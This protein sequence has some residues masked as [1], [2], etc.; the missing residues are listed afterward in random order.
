M[1]GLPTCG[2]SNC[3]PFSF[4]KRVKRKEDLNKIRIGGEKTRDDFETNIGED[5]AAEKKVAL[6]NTLLGSAK[7]QRKSSYLNRG[8]LVYMLYHFMLRDLQDPQM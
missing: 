1:P 3:P 5:N 6:S 4:P 7:R 2:T 8:G